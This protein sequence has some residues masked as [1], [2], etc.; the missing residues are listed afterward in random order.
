MNTLL[1]ILQ[2]LLAAI[3]LM[4]GFMKLSNPNHELKKKGKGSMDWT[5]DISGSNTKL[6]GVVEVLAAFG[7]ILPHLLGIQPWL[8]PVA[9]VGVAL[10]MIG[11][12]VLHLRRGDS[13]Q[14]LMTNIIILAIAAFI[15][16]GRFIIIPG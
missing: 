1:W 7:L 11:A 8:T 16:Y 9:A 10:T 15:S 14:A 13:A 2:G 5:D 6:I 4:A 3:M 12:L